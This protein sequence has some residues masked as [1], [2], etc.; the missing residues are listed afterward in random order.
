MAVAVMI[1]L[2]GPCHINGIKYLGLRALLQ[3]DLIQLAGHS[4]FP[5]FWIMPL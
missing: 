3:V 2:E 1:R 4:N 5:R